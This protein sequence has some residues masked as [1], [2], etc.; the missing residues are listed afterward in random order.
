[1]SWAGDPGHPDEVA[2]LWERTAP[3]TRH[4]A[5]DLDGVGRDRTRFG[6]AAATALAALGVT[7]SGVSS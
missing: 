1:V 6:Q 3:R 5:I 4:E 7:P 2:R